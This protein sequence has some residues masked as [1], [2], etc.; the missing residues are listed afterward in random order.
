MLG[1]PDNAMQKQ[2]EKDN[3]LVVAPAAHSD[4]LDSAFH[5]KKSRH[6]GNYHP[7]MDG[8]YQV[9]LL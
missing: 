8:C 4:A 6:E 1:A 7:F 2:I 9:V 3:A 5:S